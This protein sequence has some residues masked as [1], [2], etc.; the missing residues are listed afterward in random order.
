MTFLRPLMILAL[1]PL[2]AWSGMPHVACR[3]STGEVRLFCPKMYQS[4]SPSKSQASCG[5]ADS[6]QA[7]CCGASVASGCRGSGKKSQNQKQ[8]SC[9]ADT[10]HCTPVILAADTGLKPKIEILPDLQQI[11][12]LPI[13]VCT[14]SQPHA[15]HVDLSGIDPIP[16]VPDDLVVLTGRWLI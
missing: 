10:C 14:L 12:L 13:T 4:A 7:S 1:V 11:E 6:Q 3:C 8:P 15:A 2:M 16:L 5:S 9:C